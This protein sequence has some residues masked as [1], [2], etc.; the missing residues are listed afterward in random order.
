MPELEPVIEFGLLLSISIV[1]AHLAWKY[2]ESPLREKKN[3]LTPK[4]VFTCIFL[5]TVLI[6]AAGGYI[7]AK[8]GFPE[9]FPSHIKI[10]KNIESFDWKTFTGFSPNKSP[11]CSLNKKET[12]R[13]NDCVSGD[14]NSTKTVLVIG[15]SHAGSIQAAFDI[16]GQQ[17]KVR[18][19]TAVGPGCP[20]LVGIKSF[21]GADDICEKL[22]FDYHLQSLLKNQKFEKVYLVSFWD[23]YAR[24]SRL[25]GRLL[26][27]THF[28]S[29]ETTTALNSETS[30]L[31][32]N[33]ALTRTIALI[34]QY[35]AKVILVQDVPTL[36][37]PIQDLNDGFTQSIEEV[38]PQQT[39]I[40]EFLSSQKNPLLKTIDLAS[41][42]CLNQI[43]HTYLNS[44]YLY[45]DNNHITNAGAALA[46][47]LIGKSMSD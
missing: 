18:V 2:V 6:E 25:H 8:N 47:P 45:N 34:N 29:N 15:D 41:I 1:I 20:P 44:F 13:I 28:I 12:L 7:Y 10:S 31:V 36:P 46:I 38:R 19:I 35:G 30:Q 22:N 43:C 42:L 32:L 9:R 21:N 16:A 24:G 3:T 11:A 27:P 4:Q 23:M 5:F 14:I 26:R 17:T 39:F 40:K 37:N 33:N